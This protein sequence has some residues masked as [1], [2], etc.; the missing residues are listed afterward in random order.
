MT[1][2]PTFSSFIPVLK[3]SSGWT[4]E[5]TDSYSLHVEVN[6]YGHL[7]EESDC[8]K[9]FFTPTCSGVDMSSI[10]FENEVLMPIQ[11]GQV[12]LLSHYSYPR[13]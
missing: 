8:F 4:Q 7:Q 6:L 3:S 2:R 5:V 10:C 1:S 13:F 12:V 11:A 9:H